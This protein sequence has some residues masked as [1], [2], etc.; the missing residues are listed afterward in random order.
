MYRQKHF[1]IALTSALSVFGLLLVMLWSGGVALAMPVAGVGGFVITADEIEMSNYTMLPKVGSTSDRDLMPQATVRLDAIIKNMKLTKDLKAPIFGTVR[2]LI[3]T[4]GTVTAQ[5][6]I[7]DLTQIT[8]DTAFK[9]LTIA[10]KYSRN[11][12]E[13]LSLQAPYAKL[14]NPVIVAHQLFS[15]R[16]SIPNMHFHLEINRRR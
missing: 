12:L 5:G 10:E 4:P 14:Q 2:I 8:A 6:M 1:W 16:I 15:N 3:D 11:P 13:K 7:L 9:D